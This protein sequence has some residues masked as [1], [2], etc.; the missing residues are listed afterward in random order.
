MVPRQCAYRVYITSRHAC[1][2]HLSHCPSVGAS[3]LLT[4]H[5]VERRISFA[6][7]L[8]TTDSVQ[9]HLCCSSP[10]STTVEPARP[11]VDKPAIHHNR[12]ASCA[13]S[14]RLCG[15]TVRLV[16]FRGF[17]TRK[18]RRTRPAAPRF[19]LTLS[20][21]SRNHASHPASLLA[22]NP[23]APDEPSRRGQRCCRRHRGSCHGRRPAHLFSHSN[24]GAGR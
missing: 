3:L 11:A 17:K 2:A 9:S 10:E 23:G 1:S 20:F 7:W 16:R 24:P 6:A 22:A 19:A 15:V 8:L 13:S 12:V 21:R 14:D 4:L 18:T 5:G